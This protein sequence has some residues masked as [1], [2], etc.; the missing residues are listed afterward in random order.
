M[1][2]FAS[3]VSSSRSDE[4]NFRRVQEAK[5]ML[6]TNISKKLP[7]LTQAQKEIK[8]KREFGLDPPISSTS[9]APKGK[10]KGKIVSTGPGTYI[11]KEE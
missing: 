5:Q 4:V 7:G 10:P 3:D 8:I 9:N 2:A 1:L 6:Y 11:W